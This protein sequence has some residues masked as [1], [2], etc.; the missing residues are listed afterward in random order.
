MAVVGGNKQQKNE[1]SYSP[2]LSIAQAIVRESV[3]FSFLLRSDRVSSG[4]YA[5]RPG[6]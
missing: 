2:V 5:E 4:T 1:K 3:V 6:T